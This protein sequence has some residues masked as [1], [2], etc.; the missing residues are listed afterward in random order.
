M[1]KINMLSSAHKVKGQGVLSAFIEQVGLVKDGLSDNFDVKVNNVQLCDIMHYHTIDIKF[2][3]SIPFARLKGKTVAYV[4]F[5]PATLDESLKL[6]KLFKRILYK[7]VILFYKSV[8][9][10]VVVNPNFIEVLKEYGINEDKIT[11]IP[12]FVSESNFFRYDDDKKISLRKEFGLKKDDFVVLGVG[13]VQTRKGI[14]D[15][16]D[17]AKKM[18]E[19]KFLWAGGFSFGN[20]TEGYDELKNV[21]K[22]PP[23]NVKFLGILERNKMNDI[24]NISNTLFLP[25]YNEL[26]PMSILEAMSN[27]I[28]IVLRNLDI[29]KNIFFDSYLRGSSTLEFMNIIK[30]LK[31]NKEDYNKWCE[32]SLKC[33]KYYSKSS[34]LNKWKSFYERAYRENLKS[35]HRRIAHAKQDI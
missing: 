12:N 18:P 1:I 16:I 34:V 20:M 5:V 13:Q 15:F 24:Y 30:D 11:Y 8:D 33:H 31:E 26:F 9:Y 22:N 32:A 6:P 28:P 14:L 19:I 2:F 35:K 29:Y 4:H 10:I 7:Y 23:E 3:L 25:S 27:G 17:V 21:M